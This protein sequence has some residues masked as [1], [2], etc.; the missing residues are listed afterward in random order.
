MTGLAVRRVKLS[1][2]PMKAKLKDIVGL[3]W[4]GN[5]QEVVYTPGQSWAEVLFANPD[6]CKNYY[7]ATPNGI[8]F[9]GSKD[10]HVEVEAC[11]PESARGNVKEILEK[12]MTRCVRVMDVEA[13]WTKLALEKVAAG[14]GNK[15]AVDSVVSGAVNGVSLCP[16]C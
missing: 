11:A 5:I 10:R 3:V 8:V 16:L 4:G 14:V 1:N 13:D 6:E 12:G 15:R 2:L 9:P 7:D